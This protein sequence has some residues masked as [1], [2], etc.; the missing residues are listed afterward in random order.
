MIRIILAA[1]LLFTLTIQSFAQRLD[2]VL[3][4]FEG[5]D[6]GD[7]KATGEAFGKGP[8][9]GTLP[10]Q[11]PVEGFEGKGLVNSYPG[12]DDTTGTLTSPEFKIDRKFLSFLINWFTTCSVDEGSTLVSISP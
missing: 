4:D 8:A 5:D 12:G 6:Y 7:W 1:W 11:M 3:A 9:R 2:I 10:N